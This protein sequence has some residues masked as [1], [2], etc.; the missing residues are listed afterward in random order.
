MTEPLNQPL[1]V[2]DPAAKT[3]VIVGGLLLAF[4]WPLAAATMITIAVVMPAET[5]DKWA[6]LLI[7]GGVVFAFG[8]TVAVINGVIHGKTV[9]ID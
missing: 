2:F 5:L 7:L 9:D 8:N 4:V 6:W 1:P 3:R